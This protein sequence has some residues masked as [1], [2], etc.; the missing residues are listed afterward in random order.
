MSRTRSFVRSLASLVLAGGVWTCAGAVA[1][2]ATPPP[3]GPAAAKTED[4]RADL[5][6]FKGFLLGEIASVSDTGVVLRVKSVTVVEGSQAANPARLL[7]REMPIQFA[8]EKDKEGKDKPIKSL[9]DTARAAQKMGWLSG[10]GAFAMPTE[11]VI[12][13]LGEKGQAAAATS[14]VIVGGT[15]TTVTAVAGGPGQGAA[16]VEGKIAVGG[17]DGAQIEIP[18][19]APEGAAEGKEKDKKQAPRLLARVQADEQGTLVADR[20]A[21]GR[22]PGHE[23]DAMPRIRIVPA[24]GPAA[25]AP[26]R[27]DTEF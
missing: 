10:F 25:P 7:G 3:A 21:P 11:M 8:T 4:L 16:H 19:P 9:A 22:Q 14:M 2:D 20:V 24:P 15:H 18:L 1:A 6:R 13:D 17:P 27:R 26:K 5:A 12:T 23:W